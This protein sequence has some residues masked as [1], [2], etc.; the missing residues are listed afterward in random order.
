MD[1][2]KSLWIFLFFLSVLTYPMESPAQQ[3]PSTEGTPTV[4][5]PGT[6]PSPAVS[7]LQRTPSSGDTYRDPTTGMEFVFVK[8]GC[9]EM[10]DTFGDGYGYEKP[11]H[12]V[13]VNGLWMGKYEV[14]Q[15][16]WERVIAD[17]PSNFKGG[18]NYPV[19]Q[20]S[21]NDVQG[22]VQRLNQMSGKNHR[23]PTEAEWEYAARSGGKREKWSGTSNEDEIGGY[24]WYSAN[25]IGR[26]QPVGQKR[27]NGLGLYDMSGN[28][29]EWCQDLFGAEYYKTSPRN[30]PQGPGSGQGR[31]LREGG[32]GS[33][34]W[35]LRA[36]YRTGFDPSRRTGQQGF[37]LV[38]SAE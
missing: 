7:S 6:P 19:E 35:Y 21:W 1:A 23:L 5:I 29:R 12:E 38:F 16:Q 14:T 37:R 18:D 4:T 30:N 32:S 2:K 33:V 34:A 25:A 8:G 24:A 22:F 13:C 15:G 27:P 17:N 26:T 36:S 11:V 9:F 28:A 3:K 10:G 31:V 20:V